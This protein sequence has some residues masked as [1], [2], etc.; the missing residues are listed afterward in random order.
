MKRFSNVLTL[1]RMDK[2][3]GTWGVLA[4]PVN[5]LETQL[6]MRAQS[7]LSGP[8]IGACPTLTL[9]Q[10]RDVL[11]WAGELQNF[12]RGP[13]ARPAHSRRGT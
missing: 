6:R 9:S 12:E 7:I 11:A 3:P 2:K 8:L 13:R 1:R 5:P 4:E 10:A